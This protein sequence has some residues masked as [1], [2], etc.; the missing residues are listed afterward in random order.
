M[1][2][3]LYIFL[4]LPYGFLYINSMVS[5]LKKYYICS[6]PSLVENDIRG[7]VQ[8][9]ADSCESIYPMLTG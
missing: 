5:K 6:E 9:F 8:C 4:R 2:R 3:I 7:S 1:I